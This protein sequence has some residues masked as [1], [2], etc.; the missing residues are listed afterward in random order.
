[1]SYMGIQHWSDVMPLKG[2]G[3]APDILISCDI[4]VTISRSSN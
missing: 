1:M 2:L 3:Q 4:G